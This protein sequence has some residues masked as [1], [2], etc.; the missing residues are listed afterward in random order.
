PEVAA[1]ESVE[2]RCE[3][4]DRGERRAEAPVAVEASHR[5]RGS[6]A[7]GRDRRHTGGAQRRAE[8]REQRDE[9]ADDQ[10]DDDRARLERQAVVR[11]RE[12]DGVEEL[13][14]ALAEGE[15]GEGPDDGGPAANPEASGTAVALTVPP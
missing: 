15:A 9:D 6:L 8:A 10:R 13:E 5:Q 7:D 14:Q 4:D 12:A 3:A 2:Q 1:E 11:E